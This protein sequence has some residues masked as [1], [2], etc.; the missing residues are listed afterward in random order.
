[1][2]A[3]LFTCCQFH[4]PDGL[5]GGAGGFGQAVLGGAAKRVVNCVVKVAQVARGD[6]EGFDISSS[7]DDGADHFIFI[8]QPFI[9]SLFRFGFVVCSDE[10]AFGTADGGC[11]Q[12]QTQMAGQSQPAGVGNAL[13]VDEP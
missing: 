9:A 11:I 13:T 1:M 3:V 10:A 2:L 4:F 8:I 12:K 5:V 6:K 7:A